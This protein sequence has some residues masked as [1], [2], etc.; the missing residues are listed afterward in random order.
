LLAVGRAAET[1]VAFDRDGVRDF[2]DFAGRV[3]GLTREIEARRAGRFIVFTENSYAFAVALF[4]LAHAGAR[5]LVAPNRQPQTLAELAAR[6]DGVMLDA[7]GSDPELARLPRLDPLAAAL[8]PGHRFEALSPDTPFAELSTSGTTGP[9][10]AVPKALRHLDLEVTVLERMFGARLGD[11]KLFATVSHQHLY[12][13]LFRLLWPLAAGRAFCAETFLHN[14]ELFPR[15]RRSG[16]FALA[17]TPAHLRRMRGHAELASLRDGVR[18]VFSSGGPLEDDVAYD[19]AETLGQAPIEIFG[20][21]ET[22]GV[23]WREQSRHGESAAWRAFPG[24]T[25]SVEPSEQRL[26]VSSPFVSLGSVVGEGD[27]QET[28]MGDRVELDGAGGFRLLGRADRIVKVGEKRLALPEMESH[29]RAHPWVAEAA[30]V[31]IDAGG[32]TRVGA[33]V[34]LSET[35]QSA[36]AAQG[37]RGLGSALADHLSAYWDRVL[38]PRAWRYV[39]ELPRDPQGKVVAARLLELL[40]ASAERAPQLTPLVLAERRSARTLER[41]LRVPADLAFFEGHFPGRPIV[42]GVVQ[43]HWLMQAAA[44]LLGESP[45]VRE[46]EGLRFRDLLLPDTE[47]RMVLELSEAG[48]VLRFRLDAGP[49]VFASGRA[50]LERGAPA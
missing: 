36:L 4:A 8:A 49:R 9:G 29:L 12:G 42:A 32:E 10:K 46:L 37:R 31:P 28:A 7:G 2:A 11:A 22:G 40:E 18:A 30:L 5:A 3:A 35:G 26:V 27:L 15:M 33:V 45:R 34:A 13:L 20:S 47:F 17:T 14:E 41:D 19:I 50:R 16:A 44:E 39:S 25:L 38:L 21:S 1:P 23:A 24:V 6:A 43:L 48:D